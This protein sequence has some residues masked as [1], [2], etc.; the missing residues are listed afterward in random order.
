VGYAYI[1]VLKVN[2]AF[3][4]LKASLSKFWLVFTACLH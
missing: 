1:T 2:L 4:M 3:D